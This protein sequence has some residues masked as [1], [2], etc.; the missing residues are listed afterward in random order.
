ME[1]TTIRV[2]GITTS[3]TRKN[4]TAGTCTTKTVFHQD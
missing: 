3:T 1:M 4:S 2:G